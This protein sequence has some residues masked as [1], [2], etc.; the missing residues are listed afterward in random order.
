[1]L[2]GS[3]PAELLD[4]RLGVAFAIS[5]GAG[6]IRG[7]SGFGSVMLTA[8]SLAMLYGPLRMIVIVLVM[9]SAISLSL[10]AGAVRD[11]EWRFVGA[12]SAAAALAMPFGSLLLTAADP[13]WLIRGIGGIVLVFVLLLWSGWRYRGPKRLPIT[14]LLGTV[15]G[16][17]VGATS[18]GGPPVL[19]YML[20]GQDSARVN[21][22]NIILYFTA[23]EALLAAIMAARG[24]IDLD[25]LVTGAVLTPGFLLT[26]W[27]GARS[28]RAA[29]EA[30]YRRVALL[31]L[32]AIALFALLR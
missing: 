29:S 5:I 6:L 12:L 18:M 27:L 30:L 14:L 8:P 11:A 3:L 26:G 24:L 31:A 4:W 9:E 17:M 10:I 19:A 2:D 28:F 7:F 25:G 32:T 23:L 20:A 15:S 13:D 21:R 16:A 1:M 22:A